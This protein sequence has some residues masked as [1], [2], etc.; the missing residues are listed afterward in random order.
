VAPGA[1]PQQAVNLESVTIDFMNKIQLML[2]SNP[3]AMNDLQ[4]TQAI[5]DEAA[6]MAFQIS[7]NPPDAAT[8]NLTEQQIKEKL[9]GVMA[10][11]G[12]HGGAF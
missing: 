1:H 10:M 4:C 6:G 11:M 7:Q 12:L 8:A 5:H 2:I 9:L 3:N